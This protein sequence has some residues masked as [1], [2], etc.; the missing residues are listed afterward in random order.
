MNCWNIVS[1]PHPIPI[2]HRNVTKVNIRQ[3]KEMIQNV[4]LPEQAASDLHKL[5]DEGSL[6]SKL[7]CKVKR[8]FRGEKLFRRLNQITATVKK[9]H[10]LNIPEVLSTLY[11]S[12]ED[13][14]VPTKQ[15]GLWV[16]S[17]I[18]A[19]YKITEKLELVNKGAAELT[20]KCLN[21]GQC[22]LEMEIALAMISRIWILSK[23]LSKT[24]LCFYEQ[25]Y[26]LVSYLKMAKIEWMPDFELPKSISFLDN[27]NIDKTFDSSSES[28]E[29]LVS[30]PGS[31]MS[32]KPV[33]ENPIV[34]KRKRPG[35]QIR[36]LQGKLRILKLLLLV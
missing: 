14:N 27:D 2:C 36:L 17:R 5:Y 30:N 7:T 25:Y 29:E 34:K 21:N 35:K 26:P 20:I 28:E 32:R 16:G 31:V 9:L 11:I 22:W 8:K 23:A 12:L 3:I 19:A 18:L 4:L 1:L 24:L 6:M 10:K 15:T 33:F 13:C